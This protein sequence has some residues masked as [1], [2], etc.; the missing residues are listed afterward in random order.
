MSLLYRQ[1]ALL[2]KLLII[3]IALLSS[4]AVAHEMTPSY[5]I[6]KHSYLSGIYSTDLELF[7]RR[8][9]VKFYAIS[10]YDSE[11]NPVPFASA[12]SLLAV[13][14]LQRVTFTVH[15]RKKDLELVTYICTS[16]KL[17]KNSEEKPLVS[18]RICSKVKRD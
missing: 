3:L 12:N 14:Y 2:N 6:F 9:D 5:P 18:S 11:W 17:P 13:N 10:V 16:S 7:N 1:N 15:I 4:S 8:E